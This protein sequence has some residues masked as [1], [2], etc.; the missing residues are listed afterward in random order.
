MQ[1]LVEYSHLHEWV[2]QKTADLRLPTAVTET[3]PFS[4]LP[5]LS[6][7]I[8]ERFDG[9][10]L[11]F[12]DTERQPWLTRF[13]AELCRIELDN[14][15]DTARIREFAADLAE[16]AWRTTHSL[17]TVPYIDGIPAGTPRRAEVVWLDRVL[18]VAQLPKP[19]LAKVVPERLAQFFGRQDVNAALNYCFGRSAEEVTEY[20]EE[21]FRL[22]PRPAQTLV[23]TEPKVAGPDAAAGKS[24]SSAAIA[25]PSE[26]EAT[27]AEDEDLEVLAV[28][29]Q[30][31]AN[32]DGEIEEVE[33]E[34][35]LLDVTPRNAHPPKPAKPSIIERF[36][37][38]QGFHKDGED[39]FFHP[40]GSWIGKAHGDL[41]PWERRTATGDVVRHYWCKE[42]CLEQAPL[43]LEADIWGLI[44]KFPDDYALVLSD[45]Q[46]DPVEVLGARLREMRDSEELKLYPASYRLVI[47][48]DRQR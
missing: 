28:E 11:S 31:Q 26:P 46:G 18:H 36:A 21:N 30:R 14:E 7:L 29:Q 6:S 24:L 42:H 35:E 39:R 23:G 22:A 43:Q 12:E 3:P 17:E 20:L 10:L 19:K 2:K 32:A 37:R 33:P 4:E 47:D 16:T 15:A 45:P 41:F 38:S 5:R 27:A 34:A 8:E 1:S 44:E 40:D 25:V 9:N 48:H 13:G